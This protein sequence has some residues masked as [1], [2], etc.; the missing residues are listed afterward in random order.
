MYYPWL[1]VR[2]FASNEIYLCSAANAIG[3][4]ECTITHQIWKI[5]Y[6]KKVLNINGFKIEGV[7]YFKVFCL[8]SSLII[9]NETWVIF[10]QSI[11]LSHLFFRNN[12]IDWFFG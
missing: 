10:Q 3:I 2:A 7:G 9:T 6:G 5:A 4:T 1:Y 11:A 12:K 8:A